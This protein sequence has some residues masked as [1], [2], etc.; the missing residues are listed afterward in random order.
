MK[1]CPQCEFLYEEDQQLCDMDGTLLMPDS[2]FLIE[3]GAKRRASKSLWKLAVE[4]AFPLIVLSFV[5]FYAFRNQNRTQ[6]AAPAAATIGSAETQT[7]LDAKRPVDSASPGVELLSNIAAS[8]RVDG[9]TG[10]KS[11]SNEN[12]NE[13]EKTTKNSESKNSPSAVDP[14]RSKLT[15]V[16]SSRSNSSPSV[17]LSPASSRRRTA[18]QPGSQKRDNRVTSFFKKTG[19]FLAKPFKT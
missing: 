18:P 8:K 6:V 15:D 7:S 17:R 12:L 5:G 14:S 11:S 2:H 13:S 1:R 19:R 10:N 16:N 4:I 9:P 3:S